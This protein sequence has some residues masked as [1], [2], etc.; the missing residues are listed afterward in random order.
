MIIACLLSFQVY[1][2]LARRAA[3]NFPITFTG[4]REWTGCTY[5]VFG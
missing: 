1:A 3:V 5:E 2:S 4:I